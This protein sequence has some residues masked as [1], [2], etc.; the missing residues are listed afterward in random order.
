M[1]TYQ[2]QSKNKVNM[3]FLPDGYQ[4]VQLIL[5]DKT[6][7]V[8]C[9]VYASIDCKTSIITGD[10]IRDEYLKQALGY[11]VHDIGTIEKD[12]NYQEIWAEYVSYFKDKVPAIKAMTQMS[13]RAGWSIPRIIRNHDGELDV[14]VQID[15]NIRKEWTATDD[16]ELALL[17]IRYLENAVGYKLQKHVTAEKHSAIPVDAVA[18]DNKQPGMIAQLLSPN[19]I[20]VSTKLLHI[21]AAAKKHIKALSGILTHCD[22]CGA[23]LVKGTGVRL[24]ESGKLAHVACVVREEQIEAEQ[25]GTDQETAQ[26]AADEQ[27]QIAKNQD[28]AYN[29]QRQKEEKA[30][31]DDMKKIKKQLKGF[32]VG[33]DPAMRDDTPFAV[34]STVSEDNPALKAV[35]QVLQ[36]NGG[37]D[38]K[39]IADTIKELRD[40]KAKADAAK[41]DLDAEIKRPK[42]AEPI[43]DDGSKS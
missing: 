4:G 40:A 22:I 14:I 34:L 17:K 42:N 5:N 2:N 38:A 21:T 23:K 20:P 19:Q 27:M 15:R 9:A 13:I 33:V 10:E 26:L 43:E 16:E 36:D 29:Q 35:L 8:D 1:E 24:L 32:T 41:E 39:A 28:K 12:P 30:E 7:N 11:R 6:N 31:A 3:D 18:T 25:T 37:K